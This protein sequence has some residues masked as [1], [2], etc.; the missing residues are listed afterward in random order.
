MDELLLWSGGGGELIEK[1]D[2]EGY[3]WIEKEYHVQVVKEEKKKVALLQQC[4]A[5]TKRCLIWNCMYQHLA[6][7]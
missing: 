1:I 4:A 6:F 5:G 7:R 2:Q 3:D